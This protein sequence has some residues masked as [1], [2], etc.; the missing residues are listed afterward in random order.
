MRTT[1]DLVRNAIR[2]PLGDDINIG[3]FIRTAN[4]LTDYI[5]SKDTAN[6]L[7]DAGLDEELETYLACYF[8]ALK[9][10]QYA[11]KSTGDASGAF[12]TGQRGPGRFEA[13][14]WGLA[15]MAVDVTGVLNVLNKG[16]TNIQ[17]GWLGSPI[18]EQV[19]WYQRD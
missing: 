10:Q 6:V 12:Q 7:V 1:P 19:P 13:N 8:L 17:F 14:D 15:A 4:R 18:T 5:V 9:H 2:A 11:Q 3:G 16:I